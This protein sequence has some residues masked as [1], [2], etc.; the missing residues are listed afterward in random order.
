[1][2]KLFYFLILLWSFA[3]GQCNTSL[4]CYPAD[5]NAQRGIMF[6][7]VATNSI[8]VQNFDMEFSSGAL[9]VNIY[10]KV[11]THVGFETTPGAWTF[12][13]SASVGS[14]GSS[15][16]TP[17]PIAVNV[18]VDAGCRIAFY[19]TNTGAIT[20]NYTNGTAVGN[21]AASDV[22]VRICEGTGKEWPFSTSFSPRIPNVRMYYN[23]C[24]GGG[25]GCGI[26]PVSNLIFEGRKY[27]N[28][29]ILTWKTEGEIDMDKYILEGTDEF[30]AVTSDE[31]GLS[32]VVSWRKIAEIP[33][34]GD[35]FY[36]FI[37][38]NNYKYY[39]VHG[40]DNNGVFTTSN[41]IYVT[42]EY[43]NYLE[44]AE[45]KL[46][47]LYDQNWRIQIFDLDG[48][49]VFEENNCGASEIKVDFLN[50]GVYLIKLNFEDKEIKNKFVKI[51]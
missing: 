22:N 49:K 40:V 28:N 29:S 32:N 46:L 10:Y 50:N 23:S 48:R 8:I 34:K 36:D 21:T 19:I 51:G 33:S 35:G 25:I 18:T 17:L 44:I 13:G 9:N 4:L 14:L 47:V 1:M 27:G 3:F 7:V 30:W 42:Q 39:R 38:A 41:V 26:L 37:D 15:A 6:D 11:G 16:L 20:A 31:D 12:L 45:N 24:P 2:K 43:H 5:N